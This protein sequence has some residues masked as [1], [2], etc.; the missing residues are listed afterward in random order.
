[1]LKEQINKLQISMAKG[2][3]ELLSIR[4]VLIQMDVAG[5]SKPKEVAESNNSQLKE[6]QSVMDS[7]K[8]KEEQLREQLEEAKSWTQVVRGSSDTQRDDI[9]KQVR[10]QL[11]EEKDRNDRTMNVI[12]KGLKDYGENETTKEL[13]RDFFKD[14]LQWSGVIQQANRI[15]KW[16]EG[17]KNR[18]V[19]VTLEK[20]EDKSVLL[21][22]KRFL[23]GTQ[24]Y[25]DED[26][27]ITQQ[28]E[29]RK[30]WEKVKTARSEGKWA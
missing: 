1:M 18:H 10:R 12:V 25:L 16:T 21:R 17:G 14:E 8:I 19:R 13:A 24:I 15:G 5:T 3:Q 11:R 4:Q 7:M 2:E 9:E 20:L 29:R 23:K 6:I 28:E 30:E 26:L 22:N 27:T